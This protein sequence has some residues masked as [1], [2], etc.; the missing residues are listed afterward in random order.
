M[1]TINELI[2]GIISALGFFLTLRPSEQFSQELVSA[3][4]FP[5]A[6][7]F[8]SFVGL[9][10]VIYRS[11]DASGYFYRNPNQKGLTIFSLIIFP[12]VM[13]SVANGLIMT[14]YIFGAFAALGISLINGIRLRKNPL[15]LLCIPIGFI[16]YATIKTYLGQNM[17]DNITFLVL[18]YICWDTYN[19]SNALNIFPRKYHFFA[20]FFGIG[21]AFC[22]TFLD[23]RSFSTL[24][25]EA[26]KTTSMPIFEVNKPLIYSM[27]YFPIV[28]WIIGFLF[29]NS[30]IEFIENVNK[31]MERNA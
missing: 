12:I 21:G 27:Y 25:I 20:R 2:D 16:L 1:H 18:C 30:A 17:I 31:A 23:P 4:G 8:F 28:G 5:N 9:G 13:S 26:S 15:F 29:P 10:I 19:N 22:L 6:V 11:L 7:V 24:I 3:E 14:Y